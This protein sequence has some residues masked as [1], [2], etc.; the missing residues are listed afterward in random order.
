LENHPENIPPPKP[1][2]APPH[3]ADHQPPP[4]VLVIHRQV[5]PRGEYVLGLGVG[6]GWLLCFFGLG[7]IPARGERV[8]GLGVGW[9][10]FGGV[11][12][13]GAVELIPKGE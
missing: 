7:C 13:W 10:C 6:C 3:L 11:A 1:A 8:L 12:F 4:P 5:Q 9:G 2:K